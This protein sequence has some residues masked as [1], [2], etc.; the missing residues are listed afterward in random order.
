MCN[1]EHS[2]PV[3][4]CYSVVTLKTLRTMKA[5]T[6]LF[7]L[8]YIF[9][10]TLFFACG[11]GL[12]VLA[13]VEIWSALNISAGTAARDRFDLILE[14]IGM[15][16]IAVAALGLG[17]TVL[18]EEIQREANISSPTRVRRFLS[19]FLIVIVVSLSVECLIGVFQYVH[20]SPE[21]L[22]HAASIG[23]AAAALLATWGLFVRLNVSAEELEPHAM[24]DVQAEDKVIEGED[25][26]EE[27]EQHAEEH[28]E[29]YHADVDEKKK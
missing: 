21:Y 24:H 6:K 4:Q 11:I 25:V 16:T 19:R 20:G 5:I 17:Q 18:E 10:V 2:F 13:G 14:C 8:G 12:I 7:E 1:R 15:L 26:G 28:G 27:G 29:D 3:I 9:I 22:P 23:V